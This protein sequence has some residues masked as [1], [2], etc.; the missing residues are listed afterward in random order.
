M[1][2]ARGAKWQAAPYYYALAAVILGTFTLI[3]A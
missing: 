1:I 3:C 2:V